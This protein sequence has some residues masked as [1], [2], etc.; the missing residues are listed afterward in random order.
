MRTLSSPHLPIYR[1]RPC[2]SFQITADTAAVYFPT[3]DQTVALQQQVLQLLS[4][5][6]EFREINE[7]AAS[8]ARSGSPLTPE[9]I[10]E[11]LRGLANVGLLI[12]D[13][14][15]PSSPD[16][17]PEQG[18]DWL[19]VPT[20]SR[21]QGVLEALR[22]Y[23]AN[24]R[25]AG[26]KSRAFVP[27][28]TALLGGSPSESRSLLSQL[29]REMGVEVSYAGILETT[30]FAER[31]CSDGS[32]PPDAVRFALFGRPEA[33]ANIG[34]NRNAALL[35]TL[36]TLLVS[37]D[38]DTLCYTARAPGSSAEVRL[39]GEGEGAEAWFFANRSEVCAFMDACELDFLGEHE[40]FLGRSV[41]E[42]FQHALANAGVKVGTACAHMLE[43]L[44]SGSG[45]VLAT[46]SG[47]AG[48]AGVYSAFPFLVHPSAATRDRLRPSAEEYA[49]ISKSREVVRQAPCATVGHGPGTSGLAACM[50]LD[51]RELLPPFFPPFRSEDGIFGHMLSRVREGSCFAHLPFTVQHARPEHRTYGDVLTIRMSD[52]IMSAVNSCSVSI[53]DSAEERLQRMGKY[54]IFLGERSDGHFR[55]WLY[56]AMLSR[57]SIISQT[58][59][60]ALSRDRCTP[61]YWAEDVGGII[62]RATK[63]VADPDYFIPDEV[64]DIGGLKTAQEIV[65]QFGE[66]T[67][68]WPAIVERTK[69]LRE[70]GVEIGIRL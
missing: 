30:T 46:F 36:G 64:R 14:E 32:L 34:A 48:D 33:G 44:C 38:D 16:F 28:Q 65:R 67:Y 56:T 53:A 24:I 47:L 43:H 19:V 51:N 50:G 11:C 54:L 57:A 25:S 35:Q 58:A 12:S 60:A 63:A 6:C 13:S 62:D 31:L 37:V 42:I 70:S 8:L 2:R 21:P 7:H 15:C 40:R 10:A 66:L 39:S 68:W 61:E 27:D 18:T 52:L 49:R 4:A 41:G 20:R 26:R 1:G 69:A 22:H 59:G 55:D 3:L 45:R 29:P 9:E 5:C 23:L 17:G